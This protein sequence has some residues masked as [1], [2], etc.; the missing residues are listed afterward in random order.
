MRDERSHR[1]PAKCVIDHNIA[2]LCYLVERKPLLV[3]FSS[4]TI[5][6][7]RICVYAHVSLLSSEKKEL[8]W[9]K[10]TQDV[11]VDF[12]R[13]YLCTK[14]CTQYWRLH[15]KLYNGAWNVSANNSE[16]VSHIDLRLGQIVY[17]SARNISFSWLLPL[18]GFHFIFLYRII[19][20]H[21]KR[22]FHNEILELSQIV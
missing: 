6:S 1:T 11:F 5:F 20:W 10:W 21:W 9:K 8:L 22:G 4:L 2:I 16:T 13:P 12:R 7:V 18:D 3:I 19:A 14:Q 15:T 17:I